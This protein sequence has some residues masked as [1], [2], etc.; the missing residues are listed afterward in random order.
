MIYESFIDKVA[1]RAG[2]SQEQALVL[3]RATLETLSDR[4]SAGEALDLA[5]QLAKPLQLPL[6]P[7]REAAE[8]ISLAEFIGRVAERTDV[9]ETVATTGIRAV[10]AT[11]REAVTGGEFEDVL[12][13]LPADFA[14]VAEPVAA[15]PGRRR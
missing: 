12:A 7:T 10:F 15:H 6:R 11:L 3:T 5:A 8:R 13:Q 1:Q 4:L 2:V 9:D 14:A